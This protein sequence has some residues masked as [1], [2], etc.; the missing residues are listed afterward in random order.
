M[1]ERLKEMMSF[2]KELEAMVLTVRFS[3]LCE[4]SKKI[5][6]IIGDLPIVLFPKQH[7]ELIEL[8]EESYELVI[9]LYQLYLENREFD[10]AAVMLEVERDTEMILFNLKKDL[11]V[12]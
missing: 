6:S 1:K 2:M 7:K 5:G 8:E 10:R 4:K 9:E 3:E 11:K 12:A